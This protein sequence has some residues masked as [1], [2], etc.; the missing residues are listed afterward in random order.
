M[1]APD[2][3]HPSA[4]FWATV[5]VVAGLVAYPLSF[6]VMVAFDVAGILPDSLGPTLELI[7][8]PCV[9]LMELPNNIRYPP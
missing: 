1:T 7:Y 4:A 2:R 6:V 5:V 9:W 3:K 8:S